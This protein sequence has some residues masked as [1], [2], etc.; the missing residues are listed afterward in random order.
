MPRQRQFLS[1]LAILSLLVLA[2]CETAEG[3]GR[4]TRSAGEWI[5]RQAGDEDDD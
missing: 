4:D 3:L 1:V 2:G 5:E